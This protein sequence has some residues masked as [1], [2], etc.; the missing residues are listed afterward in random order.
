MARTTTHYGGDRGSAT[1][2]AAGLALIGLGAA[3]IALSLSAMVRQG[4]E[5]V[6]ATVVP[7]GEFDKKIYLPGDSGRVYFEYNPVRVSEGAVPEAANGQGEIIEPAPEE[8]TGTVE[9]QTPAVTTGAATPQ[10]TARPIAVS[11]ASARP[12]VQNGPQKK[13]SQAVAPSRPATLRASLKPANHRGLQRELDQI[14]ANLDLEEAVEDQKLGVAL[15]DVTNPHAPRAATVNGDLMLYAASL[16]KIAIL[17]AAFERIEA[18]QLRYDAA[19]KRSMTDMIRRSSNIEATAVLDLVGRDYV[20]R[21]LASDKYRL[22][23]RRQNGG[24]WVGKAY[25]KGTAYQRDPLHNISHGATAEQVARFY[26]LLETGQL[27]SPTAS[28]EMKQLMGH[29]EIEHKFVGGLLASKPGAK[30][31]RKSGTWGEFH[32]DSAIIEHRGRRYIAVAL[33][34]SRDG[35]SWLRDMIVQMDDAI[36]RQEHGVQVAGILQ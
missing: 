16:P 23:D 1:Q 21:L 20:N 34:Q 11:E 27:V 29:P 32:A 19:L 6:A 13:N 3:L 35:E 7:P 2:H 9:P 25:A 26:Y 18:G 28:R 4:G 17:L 31:Y 5:P 30:L 36:L 24:L 8:P 10:S 33:A 15:V 22:Y 14:I 12:A